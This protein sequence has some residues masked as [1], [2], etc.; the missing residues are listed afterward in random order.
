LDFANFEG[1][2]DYIQSL[3]FL[4]THF[5]QCYHQWRFRDEIRQIHADDAEARFVVIGF[6]YGACMARD[7][8]NAVKDDGIPIDLLVYLGGCVLKNEDKTCPANAVHVVNI[9][10]LG[11]IF[12][13]AQPENTE[14]INYDDVFHFG[15]P[16]HPRTLE[17]LARELAVVATRVPV[18]LPLEDPPPPEEAP[19]PRPFGQMPVSEDSTSRGEWDFLKPGPIPEALPARPEDALFRRPS[20]VYRPDPAL[21]RTPDR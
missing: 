14:N 5:G 13:G 17:L 15:S 1:V 10:A 6:S 4:K 19:H 3:G 2:R 7:L 18:V 21:A 20:A 16:T 12:N 8:V 9:L 11:C